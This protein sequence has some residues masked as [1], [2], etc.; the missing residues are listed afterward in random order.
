MPF[1]ADSEQV[2]TTQPNAVKSKCITVIECIQ[3]FYNDEITNY[4]ISYANQSPFPIF[5]PFYY[6][7]TSDT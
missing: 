7:V 2:Q 1:S 3:W 4:I 5:K 6:P